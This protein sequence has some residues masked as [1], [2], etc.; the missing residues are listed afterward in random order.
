[1][2]ASLPCRSILYALL[3]LTLACILPQASAQPFG[4]RSPQDGPGTLY[5]QSH[6]FPVQTVRGQD[7]EILDMIAQINADS[8]QS[9]IQR[10][11]DFGTRFLMLDNRKEV[12]EWLADRF[13]SYG[14]ADA[15][16]DSFLCY[17]DW[18]GIYIDTNIQ[19]NVIAT[20]TGASAP[21][22]EY[23]IGGHYD[24]FSYPDP[25]VAA[26]GANDNGSVV[27]ATMEIA[28]IMKMNGY[29]PE[30]TIHF[31]LFAA[32]EL[33]LFGSRYQAEKAR[34]DG[35]DIRFMYNMDMISNNPDNLEEVAIYRYPGFDWAAY[36]AA[37][38]ME[39]YTSLDVYLPDN[40][41]SGSDSYPYWRW[42]FPSMYVEERD[43]SPHWHQLSDTIGN[44][45]IEYCTQ[46]TRGACALL[47]EEQSLPYPRE[48][49]ALSSPDDITLRWTPTQNAK[50]LGYNIYRSET[51]DTGFEKINTTPA[52]EDYYAD[53]GISEGIDYYYFITTVNEA[54]EEG[55]PSPV[56]NGAR[57]AFSEI[58]L[59]VNSLRNNETTP[60]SIYQ[61]YDAI[62]Q[63]IPFEWFD[64]NLS[65]PLTLSTL[66]THRHMLWL[67]NTADYSLNLGP[68]Y[69]D[70]ANFFGNGG[71][72]L[73]S[74]FNPCRLLDN[75]TTYPMYC[76]PGSLMHEVFKVDSIRRVANSLMFQAYPD[77]GGYD[78]LRV[79]SEKYTHPNFP[80]QIYN[81]DVYVPS[82]EASVIYRFDSYYNSS[83]PM[84]AQQDKP[85]GLEYM[86]DD[87][88]TILLSF[89]LYYMDT[90]DAAEFI[91]YVMEE[92]FNMIIGV[93]ENED[94]AGDRSLTV[95]PNPF[96]GSARFT[97]SVIKPDLVELS[98][99]DLQGRKVTTIISEQLPSGEITYDW[100]AYGLARGIYIARMQI[101]QKIA[102]K[103]LV[104][105]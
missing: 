63:G 65:Q 33:G 21:D 64:L 59:V 93:P 92:K 62:L 96:S 101:G 15:K 97:F 37:D 53:A 72:M 73:V 75:V 49:Y 25:Y 82:T 41:N 91:H 34:T 46:I 24:S 40:I 74:A 45:N 98:I 55:L 9:V 12:A 52:T 67:G 58:L 42:G 5:N 95:Y 36:V 26:P 27:A 80:G 68:S 102:V 81:I 10:L 14:Y 44:C 77:E 31:I 38:L 47:M 104:V 79:D 89:P 28:R 43:F 71:N 78:T 6:F 51:P 3:S 1:M 23:V 83:T 94:E 76:P 18:G 8:V 56:V 39:R 32:E 29:Q 54:M 13:I 105:L 66:A 16:I 103:K 4:D 2:K 17:V 87:F 85:I 84:G 88:K 22:E 35:T 70:I 50:V 20:L 7:P 19:Y 60:D 11:Q 86:G 48:V 57:F 100:N 90:A 69:S 99:Y 61:F 30:A